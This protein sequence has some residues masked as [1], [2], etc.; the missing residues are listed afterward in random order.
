MERYTKE[1]FWERFGRIEHEALEF[2]R[3]L[4]TRQL[5][6]VPAMAMT[7]GGTILLGIDDKTRDIT[8]C[9]MSQQ[10]YDRITNMI[11]DQ[12]NMEVKIRPIQ[13]G[14]T[15]I[16]AIEVPSIR[17]RLITASD[18]RLL[19]RVGGTTKPL[20][21]EA[22]SRFVKLRPETPGEEQ[23]ITLPV[24]RIDI[25][26]LNASLEAGSR[27]QV[28]PGDGQEVLR[29]LK[30]LDVATQENSTGGAKVFLAAGIMFGKSGAISFPLGSVQIVKRVGAAPS[31]DLPKHADSGLSE[32]REEI[33]GPLP[34]VLERSMEFVNAHTKSFEAVVGLRR[35]QQHE[36]PTEVLREA[37]LNAL[38]HRDYNLTG[39]T[40]DI[41]IWDNLVQIHSPGS[42]PGFVTVENM[43]TEHYRRNPRMMRILKT[44]NLVEDYGEGI[45]RMYREMSSAGLPPP[46]FV[47]TD[48]SVTVSLRNESIFSAEERIWASSFEPDVLEPTAIRALVFFRR[49]GHLTR[50]RL[51]E[52]LPDEDVDKLAENLL[53]KGLLVRN[54]NRGGSYFRLSDEVIRRAGSK[55]KEPELIPAKLV[56]EIT[57]RGSISTTEASEFLGKPIHAT[58]R[59]LKNLLD[60]GLIRAEG[61]T[62][63]RRYYLL[64]GA[65]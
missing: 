37:V 31:S 18:G 17:D 59:I 25:G 53:K 58:R 11:M 62:K 30:A 12:F 32:A 50:R 15:E 46:E 27:S 61:N 1:E 52:I 16:T 13:V 57:K 60:S 44:L 22:M 35:E 28:T 41:T 4:P 34:S 56:G 49:E 6:T 23:E 36:Y 43:R 42:L 55:H 8:G 47:A 54:G 40:I 24:S 38:V 9:E 64:D 3:E 7:D 65:D 26:M 5:D 48:T 45:N 20:V 14:S 10:D 21:G 33:S 51:I 39:A 29:A 2:K 63:A 19:R